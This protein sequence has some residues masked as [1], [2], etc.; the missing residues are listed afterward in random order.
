MKKNIKF[1][2]KFFAIILSVTLLIGILNL[3]YITGYYY[4]DVY[5]EVKKFEDVPY[6]ITFANF[7]TSHGLAAFRYD[8]NDK[9]SFNFALSGEDIYHDFQTLKQFSD[10]LDKGC[11]V[12]IP[13]SYFS[14]C[15]PTD[16]PS[17]KRYYTYLDKQ[18]IRD[19]SYETL[20]NTKYL[21]VL[22]SI[23]FLFKDIIGD[24]EINSEDFMNAPA[25]SKIFPFIT[26]YAEDTVSEDESAQLLI[27]H[28]KSRAESWRSGHMVLGKSYMKQNTKL[29]TEMI[30]YCK[31]KGFKP[32]LIT[33]PVYKALTND[34]T[35]D[36]L[37]YYYFSNIEK[38]VDSTGILYL[39]YSKDERLINT[40]S[41]Y[42]NSDHMS[43]EGGNAFITIYKD[44]L[45]KN[46]IM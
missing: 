22:R 11:I 17:Q 43:G 2:A 25:E 40:P 24:Q 18:Y 15:L 7:G 41:Y 28:A 33:T 13:V 44:D 23:E 21:P 19:F 8:E 4:S 42:T 14:F 45:K 6:H 38:V 46:N 27:N 37:D 5:G 10:H 31:E 26:A 35:T 32:V 36:E 29:L 3:Q 12:T 9:S 16:E 34:F 39:D 20:I 1:F 30:N